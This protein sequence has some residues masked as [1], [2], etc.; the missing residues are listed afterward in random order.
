[1]AKIAATPVFLRID[2]PHLKAM[3][4]TFGQTVSRDDLDN[5]MM[6]AVDLNLDHCGFDYAQKGSQRYAQLSTDPNYVERTE[7]ISVSR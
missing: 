3:V 7:N 5:L 4:D 1:M 2:H 6:K